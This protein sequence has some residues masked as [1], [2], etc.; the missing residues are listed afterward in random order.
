MCLVWR[1]QTINKEQCV[2]LCEYFPTLSLY[3]MDKGLRP[4]DR[5]WNVPDACELKTE[6]TVNPSPQ[7]PRPVFFISRY[8]NKGEIC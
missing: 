7:P 4:R 8:S 2:C 3:F 6:L 5:S 1:H